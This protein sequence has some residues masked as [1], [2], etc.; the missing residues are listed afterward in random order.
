MRYETS[1]G[2]PPCLLI[3]SVEAEGVSMR[4]NRT[5]SSSLPG[6]PSMLIHDHLLS[7]RSK[8]AD[9]GKASLLLARLL[10]SKPFQSPAC[11]I[12][13]ESRSRRRERTFVRTI[14]TL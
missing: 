12:P 8:K 11:S 2:A 10:I 6:I 5:R 1:G 9:A 4:A 3:E 13:A 7:Q 14:S